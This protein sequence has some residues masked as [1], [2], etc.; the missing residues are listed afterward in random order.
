[1]DPLCAQWS[2]PDSVSVPV[3]PALVLPPPASTPNIVTLPE[4]PISVTDMRALLL[5]SMPTSVHPPDYCGSGVMLEYGSE[6]GLDSGT[7]TGSG[8]DAMLC[9]VG[10]W[11]NAHPWLAVAALAGVYWLAGESAKKRAARKRS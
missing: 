7:G 5:P 4:T 10:A 2:P 1:M 6:T 9:N 3:L 8:V 11:A